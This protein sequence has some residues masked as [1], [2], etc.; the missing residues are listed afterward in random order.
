LDGCLD[1]IRSQGVDEM[2]V[3]DDSPGGTLPDVEGA[4]VLR[5]G[6]NGP[7]AA[8]NVGWRAA[9]GEVILFVDVRSRPRPEWAR[10]LTSLFEDAS[11]AL[12]GSDV[13]IRDG[14]TLGARVS[15]RQQFYKLEKYTTDAWF[16]PYLPTCNL[17]ARRTDVEAVDG[18]QEIRS[19]ADA[20]FCWR[21]LDRPGRRLETVP[22]T[23]MEWVPRTTL[24]GYL[25]Q[26][27]RYGSSQRELRRMWA[28]R[29]APPPVGMSYPLLARRIA[30][31]VARSALAAARRRDDDLLEQLLRGGRFAYHLGYRRAAAG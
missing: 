19:G 2:I 18:C 22:E 29:G 12:A 21:V 5:S 6:G 14:E 16:R 7:Y 9:E 17:A 20:D 31:V 25:E 15:E 24:R 3:V 28:T 13:V 11:V 8:R 4:R 1:A 30:G 10:T 27:Y 23:L 26:N